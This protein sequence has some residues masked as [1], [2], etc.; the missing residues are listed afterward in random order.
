MR[1]SGLLAKALHH[2]R[3]WTAR[4]GLHLCR[5]GEGHEGQTI[6]SP[7][8]SARSDRKSLAGRC[9][10]LTN[11]AQD[12]GGRAEKANDPQPARMLATPRCGFGHSGED[13][14]DP[15]DP[16]NSREGASASGPKAT[17]SPRETL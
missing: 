10:I 3:N 13:A 14:N 4:T 8:P 17:D 2:E 16:A 7:D 5:R 12:Q 1:P 9:H 15:E 11:A 6:R